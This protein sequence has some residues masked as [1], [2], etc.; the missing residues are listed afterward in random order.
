MKDASP[1]PGVLL[2]SPAVMVGASRILT[3]STGLGVGEA[4]KVGRGG[5]VRIGSH[6]N[7]GGVNIIVGGQCH[8]LS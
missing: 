2:S 5:M 8:S 3:G 6:V 7:G 4:E 1:P